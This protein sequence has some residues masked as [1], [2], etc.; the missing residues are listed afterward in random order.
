MNTHS[1]EAVYNMTYL[2]LSVLSLDKAKVVSGIFDDCEEQLKR[3]C[4]VLEQEAY[5]DA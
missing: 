5:S 1:E 3:F 4:E 2:S